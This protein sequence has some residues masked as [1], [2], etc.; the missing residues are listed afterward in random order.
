M[1]RTKFFWLCAGTIHA[2]NVGHTTYL[3]QGWTLEFV[4]AIDVWWF[5]FGLAAVKSTCFSW[6]TKSKKIRHRAPTEPKNY[7]SGHFASFVEGENVFKAYYDLGE[8]HR[9]GTRKFVIIPGCEVK[10]LSVYNPKGQKLLS[11]LGPS[12]NLEWVSSSV[13]WTGTGPPTK[14][15]GSQ[16]ANGIHRCALLCHVIR[17]TSEGYDITA[18]IWR[19][20]IPVSR[21]AYAS[22]AASFRNQD[23]FRPIIVFYPGILLVLQKHICVRGV[24]S[25]E[26]DISLEFHDGQPGADEWSDTWWDCL[27]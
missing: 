5:W 2:T 14:I 11:T 9:S 1:W 21:V 10:R 6:A 15:T 20:S 4:I 23:C 25:E 13:D 7:L 3:Y 8:P 22:A 12:W 27:F 16:L 19:N 24:W 17:R 18:R 26:A